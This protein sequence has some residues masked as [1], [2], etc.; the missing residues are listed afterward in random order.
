MDNV[1]MIYIMDEIHRTIQRG[2]VS[3]YRGWT[4]VTVGAKNVDARPAYVV[5]QRICIHTESQSPNKL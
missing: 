1:H 2:Q 4:G 5:S 3:R